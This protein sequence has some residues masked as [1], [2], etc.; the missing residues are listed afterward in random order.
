MNTKQILT[1][2]RSFINESVK[3]K[4][5]KSDIGK[6]VKVITNCDKCGEFTGEKKGIELKDEWT[7]KYIN[8]GTTSIDNNEDEILVKIESENREIIVPQCCV[9]KQKQ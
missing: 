3:E 9:K 4:F 2:W 7:L 6:K 5:K 1:E 8:F